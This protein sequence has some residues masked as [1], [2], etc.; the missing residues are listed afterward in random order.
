[1]NSRGVVYCGATHTAYLEAALI[2]AIALRQQ[3]P[4][5]PITLISDQPLLKFLP[6]YTYQITPKFL[7]PDFLTAE[8]LT[9]ETDTYAFSSR[10]IKTRLNTLSPYQETL[11]LDADILPLQ[12]IHDLWSY[13][14]HSDLAMVAD[15]LPMVILCDHIAQEEKTYTLQQVP[16]NTVQFNSGVMLWRDTFAVQTLFEQ[17]HRE[18][19]KFRKH[20]QLALV[21][22]LYTT[23]VPVLK[24]PKTY[25]ISPKDAESA[26][27]GKL[28]AHL[29][30]C[31]GGMVAS[32][33]YRQFARLFYPDAV[34]QAAEL[35]ANYRGSSHDSSQ[36]IEVEQAL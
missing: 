32:G 28:D 15:R 8:S 3:D 30:H 18:W 5:I 23:Q 1:M 19:Q 31:W 26:L 22:A 27:S 24:L 11:F 21:R 35:I 14:A 29:L 33:K 7:T 12:P 4:Q 34:D 36:P 9:T 20:D 16:G 10:Q 2:S 6:L 17:W 25:N 13:L